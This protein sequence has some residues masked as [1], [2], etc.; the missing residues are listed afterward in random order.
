MFWEIVNVTEDMKSIIYFFT[1]ACFRLA[2]RRSN[3]VAAEEGVVVIDLR[4]HNWGSVSARKLAVRRAG[5]GRG[6]TRN[7]Q[8]G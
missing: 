5:S 8:D 1:W 4:V 2:R 3:V 7:G 6:S